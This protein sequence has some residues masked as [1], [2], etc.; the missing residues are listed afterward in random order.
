MNV[1]G[2][3]ACAASVQGAVTAAKAQVAASVEAMK[4]QQE[5]A[6]RLI[7]MLA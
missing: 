4:A 6:V 2:L 5:M 1:A 7:D 3:S